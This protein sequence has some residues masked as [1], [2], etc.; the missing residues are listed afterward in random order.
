M[1]NPVVLNFPTMPPPPVAS[2]GAGSHAS[3]AASQ[4]G[5]APIVA[6]EVMRAK[7]QHA[8]EM[9]AVIAERDAALAE[10]AELQKERAGHGEHLAME[11]RIAAEFSKKLSLS[12][13]ECRELK[14]GWASTQTRM[15]E[16]KAE[17]AAAQARVVELSRL[18]AEA[19]ADVATAKA[20]SLEAAPAPAEPFD[21]A[22]WEARIVGRIE[23]DIAIYRQRI[24]TLMEEREKLRKDNADLA[25]H[26]TELSGKK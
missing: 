10:N 25:A 11:K 21:Q 20:A 5:A 18:L 14:T 12:Q 13:K 24:Q 26:I 19:A 23:E 6:L 4:P 8:L 1:Q 15:S 9:E 17:C 3:A 2:S 16:T 22:E 7:A